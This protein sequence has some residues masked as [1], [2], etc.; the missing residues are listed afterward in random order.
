[1]EAGERNLDHPNVLKMLGAGRNMFTQFYE[2]VGSRF[3]IVSELCCNGE[4][5]DFVQDAGGLR[6]PFAR[7]MFGQIIDGLSYCHEAK[8]AHR[9][10]KLENCFLDS[11]VEVKIADFGL[12]KD[13][14]GILKTKCGTSCYMSPELYGSKSSAYDG[15]AADVFAL[16]VMLFMLTTAKQPFFNSTDEWYKRF[17]RDPKKVLK[18]RKICMSDALLNLVWNLMATDPKAR[19]TTAQIRQHPW[20]QEEHATQQNLHSY[21]TSL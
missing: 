10:M 6:E 4:L 8:L 16:G 1:L 14:E 5:F 21:F 7:T 19:P 17:I 2:K 12:M 13:T 11:Q 15:T 20:M 3:F 18:A 9:D